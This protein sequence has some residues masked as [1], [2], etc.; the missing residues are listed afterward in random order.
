VKRRK[1]RD[2]GDFDKLKAGIKGLQT[3][4]RIKLVT[5]HFELLDFWQSVA[6]RPQIE[7]VG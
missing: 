3:P 5:R 1:L 7:T 6:H 4:R 2:Y